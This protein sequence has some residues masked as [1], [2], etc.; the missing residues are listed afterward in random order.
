MGTSR[1]VSTLVSVI[2]LEKI[3]CR[4]IGRLISLWIIYCMTILSIFIIILILISVL[5]MRFEN[6]ISRWAS[7]W[8]QSTLISRSILVWIL[9]LI[10]TIAIEIVISLSKHWGMHHLH[11]LSL[12]IVIMSLVK[13][14]STTQG[15]WGKSRS[16]STWLFPIW[17]WLIS[18]LFLFSLC[19]SI[20]FRIWSILRK[21]HSC[22]WI[23]EE[24]GIFLAIFLY[25]WLTCWRFEW[26]F[27]GLSTLWATWLHVAAT[28]WHLIIILA[29]F[30]C[31]DLKCGCN[32]F[33]L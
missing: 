3:V 24:Y 19:S 17:C 21:S 27:G 9:H 20:F 10:S 23:W 26:R 28:R 25:F 14:R 8:A 1:S 33:K 31:H 29:E 6:T 2:F 11:G 7:T 30:R 32:C 16:L 15:I 13:L 4:V 22:W 18:H 12:L 5:L